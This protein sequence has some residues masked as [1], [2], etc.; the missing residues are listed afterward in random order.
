MIRKDERE[1]GRK[2]EK[3][4]EMVYAETKACISIQVLSA[5]N[6]LQSVTKRFMKGGMNMKS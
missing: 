4:S 6:N 1:C 3:I 2:T 5:N